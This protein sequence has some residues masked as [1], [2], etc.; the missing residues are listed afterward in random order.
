MPG[1]IATEL[2]RGLTGAI[3]RPD[4]RVLP[5]PGKPEDVAFAAA[6]LSSDEAEWITGTSL[7]VTG[8]TGM[9]AG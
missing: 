6:F 3:T 5:R 2:T 7:E 4:Q 8:G 9:F 1:F